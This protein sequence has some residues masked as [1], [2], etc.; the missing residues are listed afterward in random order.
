[1]AK[2]ENPLARWSARHGLTTRVLA[3]GYYTALMLGIIIFDKEARA[4]VY[5]QF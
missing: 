2:L 1:L 4:F 5:F 3:A